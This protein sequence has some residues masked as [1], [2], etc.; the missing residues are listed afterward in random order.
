MNGAMDR[1]ADYRS[2]SARRRIES[3]A[4]KLVE[5]M[6]FADELQLSDTVK[7][8]SG[9]ASEFSALGPRDSKGRSLRDFDLTKR[10]MKYPCSYLI[11]SKPFASLPEEAKDRVNRRLF[12]VLTGHD[13]SQRFA[14]LQPS[15]RRAIL[16]ILRETRADLPSYWNEST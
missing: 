12:E 1:P 13:E 16:E 8:T 9:F 5:Y 14:H 15:D 4:E 11:Y 6:L 7:G 2:D 10:M 3:A